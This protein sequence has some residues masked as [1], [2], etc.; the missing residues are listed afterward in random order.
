MT[1]RRTGAFVET[2]VDT[3]RPAKAPDAPVSGGDI[4][5]ANWTLSRQDQLEAPAVAEDAAYT[6]LYSALVDRMEPGWLGFKDVDRYRTPIGMRSGTVSHFKPNEIWEDIQKYRATDPAFLKD[7]PAKN[8]EEFSAWVKAQELARRRQAQDVVRREQ[9]LGQKALGFGTG[10]ASSFTDPVNILGMALLGPAGGGTRSLLSTVAR[11]AITN[12]A[13]E[14]AELPAISTNRAAF[15]EQMTATDMIADVGMA[16]VAGGAFPIAGRAVSAVGRPLIDAAGNAVAP[17]VRGAQRRLAP[18]ALG[19]AGIENAT[20]AEIASSFAKSVPFSQRTPEAQAGLYVL[21]REAEVQ[22][23]S[24]FVK[25]PG[26]LDANAEKLTATT[27][28]LS[29]PA[30]MGRSAP[31]AS[32]GTRSTTPLTQ[33]RVINFVLMDLEGGGKAVNLGDGGGLTK[34]GV[35]ARNNPDVDV[36][37]LTQA[38][39]AKIARQ[40]YWLPE[41]NTAD[42]RVAAIAFDANY[43]SSPKLARRIIREAGNDVDKAMSIYREH[44]N[45]L[46][47]TNPEKARFKKGWNNRLDKLGRFVGD[48]EAGTVRLNPDAFNGDDVA[49][50]AQM[51]DLNR[52]E[53]RL[54]DDTP[55]R[56][57]PVRDYVDTVNSGARATDD[58]PVFELSR[59]REERLRREALGTDGHPDPL[60]V[61]SASSI[62]E[63]PPSHVETVMAVREYVRRGGEPTVEAVARDLEI[64]KT[65]AAAALK[66]TVKPDAVSDIVLSSIYVAKK[67][68]PGFHIEDTHGD[69]MLYSVFRDDKGKAKGVVVYPAT[70]EARQPVPGYDNSRVITYVDPKFRRQGVATKLYDQLRNAGHDVDHLSG[71]DDL[72][73]DGAAFVNSRRAQRTIAEEARPAP[74]SLDPK[75]YG[76]DSP[77]DAEAKLLADSAVHDVRALADAG[78]ATKFEITEGADPMTAKELIESLDRDQSAIDIIKGCL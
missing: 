47:D 28:M 13:I 7:I 15:G 18:W 67:G 9:G 61:G 10:V 55:S 45:H 30:T 2:P 32:T 6:P 54:A 69:G 73:P 27:E 38:D 44:L 71:N 39:A 37:N 59:V 58:L 51:E 46:A 53:L 60:A 21:D 65:K 52:E 23:A 5:G 63:G 29:R 31:P 14:T 11:D 75:T 42:P 48:A 76:I 25:T 70:P 26:G 20:D 50:R 36:A 35:T 49:Y 64:T 24:P 74:P 40:R 19:R 3:S 68:E 57:D 41:F 17:A 1:D 56:G 22:G 66:A 78:N 33:D 43:I 12:M 16:G 34:Y 62:E 8:K 77:T 4:I 72:T